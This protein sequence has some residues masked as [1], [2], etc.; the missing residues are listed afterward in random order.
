MIVRKTQAF[1]INVSCIRS[2]RFNVRKC[3]NTYNDDGGFTFK[4]YY[5]FSTDNKLTLRPFCL[6]NYTIDS[7]QV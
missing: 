1:D 7:N 2:D 4:D 6:N 3:P 5:V